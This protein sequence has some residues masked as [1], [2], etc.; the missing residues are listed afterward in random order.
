MGPA[1]VMANIAT[2]LADNDT[3]ER[4]VLAQRT[5]MAWRN[6]LANQVLGDIPAKS[7]VQQMANRDVAPPHY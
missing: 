4:L 3:M 1:L 2:E 5:E 7:T 6:T